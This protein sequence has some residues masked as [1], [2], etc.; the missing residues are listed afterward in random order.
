[1][2]KCVDPR[3]ARE[4]IIEGEEPSRENELAT[5]K[6]PCEC[7]CGCK[8]K[9][10]TIANSFCRACNAGC[11]GED[12]GEGEPGQYDV[13]CDGCSRVVGSEDDLRLTK[14]GTGR[15]VY[16]CRWCLGCSRCGDDMSSSCRHGGSSQKPLCDH[17]AE[18]E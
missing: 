17:C 2:D 13:K 5:D 7:R 9:F 4:L 1:M 8:I 6:Y 11:C 12:F 16:Y 3:L 14:S 10:R 18:C 15:R